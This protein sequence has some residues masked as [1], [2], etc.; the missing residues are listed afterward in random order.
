MSGVIL[1]AGADWWDPNTE[2]LCVV[3]A[4]RAINTPGN[5]WTNDRPNVYADTL[6]N[7]ANPG[8]FDLVEVPPG[9][10]PWTINIG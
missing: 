8:T 9:P 2:G 4:Y 1:A 6:V 5:T 3:A 10:I 7:N